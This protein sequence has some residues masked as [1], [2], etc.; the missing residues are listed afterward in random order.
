MKFA[1]N[2]CLCLTVADIKI[3]LPNQGRVNFVFMFSVRAHR[4]DMGSGFDPSGHQNRLACGRCGDDDIGM[5]GGVFAIGGGGYGNAQI[6]RGGLGAFF[7]LGQ[8]TR[9]NGGR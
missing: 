4:G 3:G 1:Q 5:F 6:T 2:P 7:G 8:I 9:P